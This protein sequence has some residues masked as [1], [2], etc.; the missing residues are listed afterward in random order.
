MKGV[1]NVP[2]PVTAEEFKD[3]ADKAHTHENQTELDNLTQD[4]INNSHTHDNKTT[5][6]KITEEKIEEWDNKGS[7]AGDVTGPDKATEGNLPVFAD[8]TGKELKDSGVNIETLTTKTGFTVQWG[9][10]WWEFVKD[11]LNRD[12]MT[13]HNP[14]DFF[15]RVFNFNKQMA[16]WTWEEANS[17]LQTPF[18]E[19]SGGV[20]TLTYPVNRRDQSNIYYDPIINQLSTVQVSSDGTAEPPT[21]TAVIIASF[22]PEFNKIENTLW[23]NPWLF[24][25]PQARPAYV[26][27]EIRKYAAI[28]YLKFD[29]Y[30]YAQRTITLKPTFSFGPLFTSQ[31][32]GW[33]GSE[34]NF[35]RSVT[36]I[37]EEMFQKNISSINGLSCTFKRSDTADQITEVEF[38]Y[39]EG[40]GGEI[41][42]TLDTGTFP[43]TIRYTSSGWAQSSSSY[44]E[45]LP[46]AFLQ[47]PSENCT[48]A[49]P[50]IT[51]QLSH[52]VY[53]GID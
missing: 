45:A 51:Y 16:T 30:D 36:P 40:E 11:D 26:P 34:D 24:G 44:D 9:F 37:T 27:P 6:D 3:V 8:G 15:V 39:T 22:A 17:Q 10:A 38:K 13:V 1:T 4:V 32:W 53:Y 49:D 46:L 47:F 2:A 14:S 23:R 35:T 7:G 18:S 31:Y 28:T 43:G 20:R 29:K 41:F 52:K 42:V 25:F 19:Y 21:N 48:L 50:E 33:Y 12:V 5:L